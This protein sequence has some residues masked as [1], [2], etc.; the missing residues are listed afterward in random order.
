MNFHIRQILVVLL[1]LAASGCVHFHNNDDAKLAK[2]T[3]D[4]FAKLQKPGGTLYDTMLANEQK[5][6]KQSDADW[7][8]L[9]DLKRRAVLNAIATESFKQIR[10]DLTATKKSRDELNQS[11]SDRLKA[12]LVQMGVNKDDLA[13]DGQVK[14]KAQQL[15]A[16]ATG[17]EN[18]AKA[19]RVF[20]EQIL[21][22]FAKN[23][24]LSGASLSSFQADVLNQPVPGVTDAAGKPRT[25]KDVLAQDIKIKNAADISAILKQYTY[26]QFDPTSQPGI[27]VTICSLG[28]DLADAQLKRA[29]ADKDYFSQEVTLLEDAEK[30]TALLDNALVILSTDATP[31]LKSTNKPIK[32]D[33]TQTPLGLISAVRQT[34]DDD[35]PS[36]Q[37]SLAIQ[38]ILRL[39]TEYA[40]S[41]TLDDPDVDG[42]R[43]IVLLARLDHERSIQVSAVD[44][45]EREAV[46][47]RGLSA[48]SVYHDGGITSEQIAGLMRAFQ[49]AALAAI[50]VGVN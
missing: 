17:A 22:E 9:L 27:L 29:Q 15:L 48:L 50:G 46:I 40:I 25:V 10:E 11:I 42:P 49:T 38:N 26:G 18:V 31:V 13:L 32:F 3:S 7:D 47:G 8:A 45:A 30:S 24:S 34:K 21:A 5:I 2:D 14:A 19:R 39:V 20:F 6:S 43:L 44:A 1:L 37:K 16:N 23:P 35:L 33:D 4:S 28:V 36:D 41:S 12:T